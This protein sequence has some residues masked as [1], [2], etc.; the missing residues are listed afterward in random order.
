M[1]TGS[2]H[3]RRSVSAADVYISTLNIDATVNIAN[4][5]RLDG[6]GMNGAIHCA[7]GLGLAEVG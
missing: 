5:S 7:A 4:N 3:D 1:L 6:S 2:W